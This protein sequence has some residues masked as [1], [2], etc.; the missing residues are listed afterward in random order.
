[1]MAPAT[2]QQQLVAFCAFVLYGE[3]SLIERRQ[4]VR[5][6]A[7]RAGLLTPFGK[8]KPDFVELVDDLL[9]TFET[10]DDTTTTK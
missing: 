5:T 3:S 8:L 7:N 6:E 1:M 2:P 9:Y 4:R 10:F